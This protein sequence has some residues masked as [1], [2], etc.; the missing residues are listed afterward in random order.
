MTSIASTRQRFSFTA[1]A[2]CAV[3]LFGLSGEARADR[4][5]NQVAV[6][7]ALDKVTARTSKFEV[8][9]NSTVQFGALKVTPRVCYSRPPE[10][11]PKTTSFVEVEEV[12]LDGEEKRIFSGWMFAE[13]PGLNAVE[14][15]VFDVWLAECQKPRGSF[16]QRGNSGDAAAG[17]AAAGEEMPPAED[18]FFQ[19]RRRVRR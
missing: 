2:L 6:F 9:L 4:I 19:P 12:Q 3:A 13:S 11:Q 18:D 16:A 8:P 14:H 17:A 5:E 1:T 15:P 10:E 7:S